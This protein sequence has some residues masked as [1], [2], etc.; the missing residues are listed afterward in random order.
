MGDD[1]CSASERSIANEL[2]AGIR[3]RVDIRPCLTAILQSNQRYHR[4]QSEAQKAVAEHHPE[5]VF[6]LYAQVYKDVLGPAQTK[7]W[8]AIRAQSV[9]APCQLEIVWSTETPGIAD[10]VVV[11][12]EHCPKQ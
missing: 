11:V 3:S 12:G 4:F 2:K 1:I 10:H 6:D 7:F 9:G 8:Q 5:K